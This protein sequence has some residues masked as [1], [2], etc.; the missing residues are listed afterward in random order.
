[1]LHLL[2]S[3]LFNTLLLTTHANHW[4]I[5]RPILS[6]MLAS[7]T[8][9]AGMMCSRILR[10]RTEHSLRLDLTESCAMMTMGEKYRR[11]RMTVQFC[12][13]DRQRQQMPLNLP[14]SP[15]ATSTDY[16]AELVHSQTPENQEKLK[17]EFLKLTVDIQRSVETA[18]RDRFTQKLTVF[19][20]NVR[21]FLSF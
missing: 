1:V 21:Q 5:T 17:E 7:E 3:S 13:A 12:L 19:R 16:Q 9:F 14:P 4:A 15:T 18:N 6:L 11:A 8:S 20:L 10:N 2:M